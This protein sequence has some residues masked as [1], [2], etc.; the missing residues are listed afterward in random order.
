MGIYSNGTR[1]RPISVKFNRTYR[2]DMQ[3]SKYGELNGFVA[4]TMLFQHGK[5]PNLVSTFVAEDSGS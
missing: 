1:G 5:Q 3:L 2:C 4:V